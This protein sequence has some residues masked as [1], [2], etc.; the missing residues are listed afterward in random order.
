[1]LDI[2]DLEYRELKDGQRQLAEREREME[3]AALYTLQHHALRHAARLFF[4]AV[5]FSIPEPHV[6]P[7]EATEEEPVTA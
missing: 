2:E 3:T 7:D 4:A 1:M 5:G 6:E